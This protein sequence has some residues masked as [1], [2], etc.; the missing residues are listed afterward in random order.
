MILP[1]HGVWACGVRAPEFPGH[2]RGGAS[3]EHECVVGRVPAEGIRAILTWPTPRSPG[4]PQQDLAAAKPVTRL[5]RPNGR[6]ETFRSE[7]IDALHVG[8]MERNRLHTNGFPSARRLRI[9]W[10]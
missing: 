2:A 6:D 7:I 5:S 8:R 3:G 9:S 4:S 1:Q 10:R